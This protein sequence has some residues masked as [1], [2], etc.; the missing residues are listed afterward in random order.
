MKSFI[1]LT[2]VTAL[3]SSAQV[4]DRPGWLLVCEGIRG[5]LAT[6]GLGQPADNVQALHF[7]FDSS[8]KRCF[9][10]ELPSDTIVEGE[11]PAATGER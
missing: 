3:I 8:E 4:S 2:I 10:E 7:Y 6:K 1:G 5:W 9:L 11:L